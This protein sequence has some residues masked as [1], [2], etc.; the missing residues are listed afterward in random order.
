MKRLEIVLR[1]KSVQVIV[2]SALGGGVSLCLY[3]ALFFERPK[4]IKL[5]LFSGLLLAISIISHYL[6]FRLTPTY[7]QHFKKRKI[8][9]LAVLTLAA[10]AIMS[11]LFVTSEPSLIHTRHTFELIPTGQKNEQSS[12][13]DVVLFEIRDENNEIIPFEKLDPNN[14]WESREYDGLNARIASDD[15]SDPILYR[16]YGSQN[17]S[18]QVLFKA[19]ANSGIALVRLDSHEKLVDL[20]DR[21]EGDTIQSLQ[22]D[23]RIREKAGLFLVYFVGFLFMVLCFW[24]LWISIEKNT[25][26]RLS[27][28]VR[29]FLTFMSKIYDRPVW[30]LGVL[31]ILSLAFHAISILA[32]PLKVYPDSGGYINAAISIAKYH[33]W[34]SILVAFRG[35]GWAL[36][37]SPF[38]IIFGEN[39]WPVK[40]F[41]HLLGIGQVFLAYG[42]GKIITQ[43]NWFAFICGLLVLL[44]PDIIASGNVVLSESVV[45]F[46]VLLF[47][48]IALKY[49]QTGKIY[50]IYFCFLVVLAAGSLRIENIALAFLF[51]ITVGI[52]LGLERDTHQGIKVKRSVLHLTIGLGLVILP[53]ALWSNFQEKPTRELAS[54]YRAAVV[55]SGWVHFGEIVGVSI[56]DHNSPAVQ[57][58]QD[59]HERS[60][61]SYLEGAQPFLGNTWSDYSNMISIGM[62]PEE[63]A[64]IF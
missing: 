61:D 51:L 59:A 20:F 62:T 13:A 8:I 24:G 35:P 12:S 52:Q 29:N 22:V 19:T 47:V 33:D 6:L 1:Q 32:T 26:N 10:S 30:L 11:F 38:L 60:R 40:I 37:F 49:L 57:V 39:P 53:M 14:T 54:A 23:Y 18:I 42:V 64:Q 58:I 43:K 46:F 34:G 48:F 28:S 36:L 27:N 55:Y 25:Y 15:K 45:P 5:I 44:V 4:A 17:D 21:D 63:I 31:F 3:F 2:S 7:F 41:L 56:L 50:L 16:F 9:L